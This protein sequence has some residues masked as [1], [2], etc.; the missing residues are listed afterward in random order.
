MCLKMVCKALPI[1]RQE[2]SVDCGSWFAKRETVG[3]LD[4]ALYSHDPRVTRPST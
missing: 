2:E 4:T 1:R 3:W